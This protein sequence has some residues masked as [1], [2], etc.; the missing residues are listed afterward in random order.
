VENLSPP[1]NQ[2]QPQVASINSDIERFN[3]INIRLVEWEAGLRSIAQEGFWGTG[4]G[5]TMATLSNFYKS[6]NLPSLVIDSHN[7]YIETTLEVGVP[8][9]LILL[10]CLV[11]PIRHAV[12]QNLPILLT[13]AIMTVMACLTNCFLERAR[14]L[15]FYSLFASL[16]IFSL[17][18]K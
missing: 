2:N 11:G 13:V 14:G 6:I 3:S 18:K 4:T 8:G 7:Q 1:E 12:K 16:Y 17:E 9:L 5:G 15:Y 10:F